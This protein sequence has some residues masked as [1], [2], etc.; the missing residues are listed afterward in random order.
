MHPLICALVGQ[1]EAF[2]KH[3]PAVPGDRQRQPR[4]V[5]RAHV[6]ANSVV[7]RLCCGG[8]HASVVSPGRVV[9]GRI[10]VGVNRNEARAV[11]SVVRV[12]G[13]AA[14]IG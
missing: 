2:G 4:H 5:V 7:N 11:P 3:E 8:I 6:V 9:N 12:Q 1:P 10:V 14:E 13:F